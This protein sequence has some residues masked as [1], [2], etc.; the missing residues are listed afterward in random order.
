MNAF[1]FELWQYVPLLFIVFATDLPL[2]WRTS[3]TVVRQFRRLQNSFFNLLMK[4]NTCIITF[5]I[6][7]IAL[8]YY[9]VLATSVKWGQ[10]PKMQFKAMGCYVTIGYGIKY[11]FTL[12]R[13]INCSTY[14][15]WPFVCNSVSVKDF[16]RPLATSVSATGIE[17]IL[18]SSSVT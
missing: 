14:T 13:S 1:W 11:G 10:C 8:L 15:I 5:I 3:T 12:S 2:V 16:A 6:Q 18:Q 17:A 4:S 7:Y 9:I